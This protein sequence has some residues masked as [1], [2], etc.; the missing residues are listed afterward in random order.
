[1]YTLKADAGDVKALVAQITEVRETVK[2]ES[3]LGELRNVRRE[4]F[5]ITLRISTL[6]KMRMEVD[7]ILYQRRDELQA[8]QRRLEALI[9]AMDAK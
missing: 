8:Q 9:Q 3:A 6:D 5:D 1:M 7:V 2:R 4:L